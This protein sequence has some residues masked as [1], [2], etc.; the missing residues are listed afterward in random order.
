MKNKTK[1]VFVAAST[2]GGGAERMQLNILHS[3]NPDVYTLHFINIGTEDAPK[4][5]KKQIQY[6]KYNKKNVRKG[7]W[8]LKRDLKHIQPDYLFTT[9]ILVAYLLHILN[10]FFHLKSKVI[11][12][13]SVP[14]SES[15]HKKNIKYKILKKIN[16]YVLKRV[17]LV[18]AQTQFMKE[19]LI[20]HYRIPENKIQVIRNSIDAT[21]LTEK[22][23]EFTPKEYDDANFNLVAVGA[24]YPVKGFDLLI[25]AVALLKDKIENIRLYIVGDVRYWKN[26]DTVLNNLI[27]S[28]SL[29]NTVFLLGHKNNPFPYIKKADLFVLSSRNEGFP[30]VVLEALYLKT[31]VIATSCVDFTG[32]IQEEKNGLVVKTNSVEALAN[33]I[34][35][36]HQ[37][38]KNPIFKEI[39]N[40]DYSKIFKISSS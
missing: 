39:E 38:L 19:D 1:V 17:H 15:P 40:F 26:Y 11:V 12:R 2:V 29:E 25:E 27:A 6:R 28:H 23:E 16:K 14:P 10:V 31:P 24:L 33:G 8:N 7:F 9:S 5:L 34:L 36:G 30:N 20:Q 22:S 32:V 3:L 21:F 35:L 18:I 37:E 4:E 13:I